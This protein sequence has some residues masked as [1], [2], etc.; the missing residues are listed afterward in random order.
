MHFEIRLIA[1]GLLTL[2]TGVAIAGKSA[3]ECREE[4]A[5]LAMD[6]QQ[7]A[8]IE[9]L[10][11]P[12]RPAPPK[13]AAAPVAPA[14]PPSTVLLEACN[15]IAQADKRLECLKAA[16]AQMQQ[17]AKVTVH[18][19]LSRALVGLQGSLESG[20]SLRT[21]ETAVQEVARELAIF[22][23]D[24]PETAS[25]A[26]TRLQNAL[27]VYGDA[28]R[29]WA[30]SIE[31]YARRDNRLAYSGG[32]PLNLAG[33][34][35]LS[36]KYPGLPT[37]P[38]DF[39]GIQVGVPTDAGRLYLWKKAREEAEAGLALLQGRT[40]APAPT[41]PVA[42]KTSST[43]TR[44]AT[45]IVVRE[46]TR[47]LAIERDVQR[48]VVVE[49]ISGGQDRGGLQAGD[50]ITAIANT[51]VASVEEFDAAIAKADPQKNIPALVR[52]GRF[53]VYVLVK[54]LAP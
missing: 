32:L 37:R 36:S 3:D 34:A 27:E 28:G 47:D 22:K 50:I 53:A 14:V 21:Y 43:Q 16:V 19:A 46:L 20:M 39:L 31:F 15:L 13:P 42:L 2:A 18:D 40:Q 26:L 12:D 7:S 30:A 5:H 49:S 6:L 11:N 45:G 51:E 1:F 25:P 54:P 17:P 35:W 48:G 8:V 38:S 23:R 52:R 33:V 10:L 4:N 9:C 44:E 24:A 29:F 41:K